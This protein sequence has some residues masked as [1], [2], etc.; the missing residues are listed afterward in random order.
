MKAYDAVV[1]F[2]TRVNDRVQPYKNEDVVVTA[3][4]NDAIRQI[5]KARP[6]ALSSGLITTSLPAE[7]TDISS[8]GDDLP[9]NDFF[10]EACVLFLCSK[11][12]AEAK[13]M[14]AANEKYAGFLMELKKYATP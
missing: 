5:A 14:A 4:L 12:Y 2:R 3:W 13:E 8:S 7:V 1:D 11:S 6:D 9:V 10:K